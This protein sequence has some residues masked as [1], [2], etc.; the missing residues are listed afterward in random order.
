[1]YIYIYTWSLIPSWTSCLKIRTCHVCLNYSRSCWIGSLS[2]RI[3]EDRVDWHLFQSCLAAGRLLGVPTVLLVFYLKSRGKILSKEVGDW[4]NPYR[5]GKV[6]YWYTSITQNHA[7][8]M[9][10]QAFDYVASGLWHLKPHLHKSLALHAIVALATHAASCPAC[11]RPMCECT[12]SARKATEYV[13]LW[14]WPNLL[15][16]ILSSKNSRI[17]ARRRLATTWNSFHYKRT[18]DIFMFFTQQKK[19]SISFDKT[20]TILTA[21]LLQRW[22]MCSKTE[23]RAW[24]I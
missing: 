21:H 23:S 16:Q 6:Q 8:H 19:E 10:N 7:N 12:V 17:I 11:G 13:F 18:S 5:W 2:T 4:N 15:M 3:D 9:S 1:M 20:R 22:W 14:A 24:S